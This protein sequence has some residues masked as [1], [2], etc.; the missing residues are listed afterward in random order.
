MEIVTFKV[1]VS[2]SR[3]VPVIESHCSPLI[4]IHT[5]LTYT[6]C[7]NISNIFCFQENYPNETTGQFGTQCINSKTPPYQKCI[8][9]GLKHFIP[10]II[11]VIM[12]DCM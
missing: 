10:V 9:L 1:K 4:Q 3:L 5:L 8:T 12:T 2:V 7:K 6:I 11:R